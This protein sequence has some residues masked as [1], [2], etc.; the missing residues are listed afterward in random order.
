[1]FINYS[2]LPFITLQD[3]PYFVN[4]EKLLNVW[5]YERRHHNI[6]AKLKYSP[7]GQTFWYFTSSNPMVDTD[8]M[9]EI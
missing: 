5:A 6:I 4:K 2:E 8:M 7:E 9:I 1:M 3:T